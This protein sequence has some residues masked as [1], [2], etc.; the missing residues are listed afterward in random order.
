MTL[1]MRGFFP[2]TQMATSSEQKTCVE[3][4]REPG[5]Q[6]IVVDAYSDPLEEDT[7]PRNISMKDN[8]SSSGDS[9]TLEQDGTTVQEL[10]LSQPRVE[11]G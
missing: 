8:S 10:S 2:K 5:Q 6:T 4:P 9:Q 7:A 11:H 3:Q 1:S